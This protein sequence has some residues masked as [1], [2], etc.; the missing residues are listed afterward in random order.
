MKLYKSYTPYL[1]ILPALVIY[2]AMILIP[3][4]ATPYYSLHHTDKSYKKLDWVGFDNY[5]KL[6]PEFIKEEGA[7][8]DPTFI[9]FPRTDEE[10]SVR[11][12]ASALNNNVVYLFLTLLF[13]VGFGLFLA[14][15]VS[16]DGR[17]Y[18]MFRVLFFAPMILSLVVV[19]ILFKV[20]LRPEIGLVPQFFGLI[21]IESLRTQQWLADPN[22][23]LL[24]ISIISGWV[25]AGFYLVLF[26]AGLKRIPKELVEAAMVDGATPRQVFWRIQFPLL[27]DVTSVCIL[28]CITGA[29]KAY[30]LFWVLSN[31]KPDNFTHIVPTYIV[32]KAFNH[33]DLGYASAIAMIVTTIIFIVTAIHLWRTRKR[34]KLQF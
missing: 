30:D 15:L 25:Y 26:S 2:S 28:L 16:R 18:G 12:F 8:S 9:R 19:G 27:R 13:E 20:M 10:I 21:G 3:A 33:G 22:T 32:E 7:P 1:L 17:L 29:F 34:E 23:A 31:S 24:T 11:S 5:K 6:A 14:A 4:M